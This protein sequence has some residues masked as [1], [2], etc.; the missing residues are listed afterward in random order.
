MM[1]LDDLRVTIGRL[2]E[3]RAEYRRAAG[4]AGDQD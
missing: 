1:K 3:L 2:T 4:L